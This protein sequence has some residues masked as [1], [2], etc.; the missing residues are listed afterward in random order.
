[1]NHE[2]KVITDPYNPLRDKSYE[3]V[4]ETILEDGLALQFVNNQTEEL[5]KIAVQQNWEA[6]QFV[7]NQTKELCNIALAQ[8]EEAE[9]YVDKRKFEV[10][11]TIT[12]SDKQ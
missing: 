8:C 11:R 6:L 12:V 9:I 10:K 2:Y 1:M 4:K 5:C 7:K 3:E